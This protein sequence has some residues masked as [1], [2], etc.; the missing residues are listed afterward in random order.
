MTDIINAIGTVTEG[1][2]VHLAM[3]AESAL[4][5]LCR[6]PGGPRLTN[7]IAT[8]PEDGGLEATCV[9]LLEHLIRPSLMCR[10]CFGR[11]LFAAYHALVREAVARE[12]AEPSEADEPA[13]ADDD[14]HDG[15][16]QPH[17]SVDGLVDCAGKPL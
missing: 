9:T 2:K 1:A 7:V 3:G 5:I 8:L 10:N 6:F 17:P 11:R 4:T 14:A 12:T 13:E 16:F 15:C